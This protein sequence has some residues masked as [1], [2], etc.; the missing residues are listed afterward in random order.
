[1]DI[2]SLLSI[3]VGFGLGLAISGIRNRKAYGIIGVLIA[4]AA[5]LILA[6]LQE[7]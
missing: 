6:G 7:R 4:G 2:K 5:I 3:V 1:M